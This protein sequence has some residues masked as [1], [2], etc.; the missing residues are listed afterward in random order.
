[1]NTSKNETNTPMVPNAL[2]SIAACK[3][4]FDSSNTHKKMRQL[5]GALPPRFRG[6]ICIAGDMK[7]SEFSRE[8]DSFTNDE[9]NKIRQGMQQ[10]KELVIMFDRKIGDVRHIKQYQLT[11]SH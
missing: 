4:L 6:M 9:L 10:L 11:R 1:M 7:A 5:W 2:E 3:A 8:F